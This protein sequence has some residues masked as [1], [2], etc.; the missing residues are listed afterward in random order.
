MD[1][2]YSNKKKEFTIEKGCPWYDAQH[3]YG[4]ANVNWCE[5]TICS[6]INEPANTWSNLSYIIFAIFMIKKITEKGTFLKDFGWGIFFMG[7][8][9]FVYHATN[10]FMTQF[11]DFCGMFILSS[12][13]LSLGIRRL[14]GSVKNHRS[15]FWMFMFIN[16]CL[17][18]LFYLEDI[19]IQKMFMLN[20][21]AMFAMEIT[22]IVR[23]KV[24]KDSIY[25]ALGAIT[26]G[27]A[28]A[29]SI[30]DLKRIWCE[31]ANMFLHGHAIWHVIGGLSMFFL[32]LH[33]RKIIK[34]YS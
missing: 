10:N 9:S 14:K 30:M 34:N 32:F 7:W 28:Q 5:P 25:L 27:I 26:I 6:V 2:V 11:L 3:Q 13:I 1:L 20:V 33:Y 12:L 16:S 4:P 18:W 19:A 15:L 29:F 17:F 21:V 24:V 23:E 22:C 8:C 31:P